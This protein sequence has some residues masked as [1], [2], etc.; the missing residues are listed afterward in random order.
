M[1]AVC[2][3]ACPRA[4]VH[5]QLWR[6]AR[7]HVPSSTC[8][9]GVLAGVSS[10]PVTDVGVYLRHACHCPA[11]RLADNA[12]RGENKAPGLPGS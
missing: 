5:L 8:N 1:C 2:L 9:C 3:C 7:V 6:P 4:L 12:Q 10:N 11:V